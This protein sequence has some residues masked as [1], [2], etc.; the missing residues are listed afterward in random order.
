MQE[1]SHSGERR[2]AICPDLL[3]HRWGSQ[4]SSPAAERHAWEAFRPCLAWAPD[5]AGAFPPLLTSAQWL[6]CQRSI[7]GCSGVHMR[8]LGPHIAC[9]GHTAGWHQHCPGAVHAFC[10]WV[11]S[12]VLAEEDSNH[13]EAPV[14]GLCRHS[15]KAALR[16]R[17]GSG[18]ASGCSAR[19]AAHYCGSREL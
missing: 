6:N 12:A 4:A 10:C 3:S 9:R 8:H 16:S 13:M 14:R 19:A 18:S 7:L 1:G 17:A 5:T 11:S 15:A 2:P